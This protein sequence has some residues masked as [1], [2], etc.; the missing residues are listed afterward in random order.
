MLLATFAGGNASDHFS[1]IGNR[2]LGVK[3]PL[4]TRETL[5]NDLGVFV[6]KNAH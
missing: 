5:T 1:A 2:L 3:R 4:R 6:D